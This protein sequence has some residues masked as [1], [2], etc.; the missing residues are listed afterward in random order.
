MNSSS[1]SPEAEKALLAANALKAAREEFERALAD[2]E[3]AAQGIADCQIEEAKL[4]DTARPDNAEALRA[5][6]DVRT[7]KDLFQRDQAAATRKLADCG[8]ILMQAYRKF[9]AEAER[10]GLLEG[11]QLL[12]K[13]REAH[14]R[15]AQ[16]FAA[17]QRRLWDFAFALKENSGAPSVSSAAMANAKADAVAANCRSMLRDSGRLLAAW[18]EFSA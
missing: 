4:T 8:T 9:L 15:A 7:K 10:H 13:I 11:E 2:E 12:G 5:L 16:P 3:K 17:A 14:A 1:T 6:S 18:Q